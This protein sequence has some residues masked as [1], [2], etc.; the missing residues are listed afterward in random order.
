VSVSQEHISARERLVEP[1]FWQLDL[2][3]RL[4][5]VQADNRAFRRLHLE[6]AETGRDTRNR[7]VSAALVPERPIVLYCG[8]TGTDQVV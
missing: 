7:G 5:S 3:L 6:H 4:D 2:V 1:L 8:Y